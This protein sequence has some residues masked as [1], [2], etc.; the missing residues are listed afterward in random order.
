MTTV[1]L[2]A[3]VLF[4]FDKHDLRNIRPFSIMQL[5]PLVKKAQQQNLEIVSIRLSGHADR[6]N[7][8][9]KGDYNQRLSEK[10]VATVRDEL[11]RLGVPAA[12]ITTGASGDSQQVEGCESRFTRPADLQECLLPNRRVEVLVETRRR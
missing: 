3:H 1:Q 4:N 7:N 11:V 5:E 9:G 12:V 2:T 6:L 10:R 8:T